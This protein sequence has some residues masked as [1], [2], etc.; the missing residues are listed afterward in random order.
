[1]P[2]TFDLPPH[3]FATAKRRRK[4]WVAYF[5]D[6]QGEPNSRARSLEGRWTPPPQ[7]ADKAVPNVPLDHQDAMAVEDLWRSLPHAER[8]AIRMHLVE[9]LGE[10]LR[11]DHRFER[12]YQ[13]LIGSACNVARE[14]VASFVFLAV[15][16]FHAALAT[17]QHNPAH[18]G[19]AGRGLS[20]LE[21]A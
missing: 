2:T 7:Y 11:R 3:L 17:P 6:R 9:G 8:T 20:Q 19:I 5:A 13:R 4:N 18:P 1:M 14:R 10:R 15:Q 21:H 12:D 16:K